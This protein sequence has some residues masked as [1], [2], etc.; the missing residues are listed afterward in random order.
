MTERN[1]RRRRKLS[2]ADVEPDIPGLA[3]L[4]EADAE[5]V[6]WHMPGYVLTAGL[7]L[8]EGRPG[9]GKTSIA[10][11][12]AAA[13]SGGRG[14]PGWSPRSAG[15]VIWD[16]GEDGYRSIV[17]PR[18]MAAGANLRYI[19]RPDLRDSHGRPRRL[20][21]PDDIHDLETMIT[22]WPAR[23]LVLDPYSSCIA[24]G[25]D[26]TKDQQTR[27]VL[28]PLGQMLERT[29]CVGLITRF[30]RKGTLGDVTEHGMGGITVTGL[31]RLVMRADDHP[32]EAG[33]YTLS[34]VRCKDGPR[35]ATHLFRP[36]DAGTGYPHL[37][38][39]GE[40]ALTASEIA[41]GGADS[42][43]RDEWSEADRLLYG[44]IGATHCEAGTIQREAQIAGISWSTIR[45]AK[46]RLGVKTKREA[47][48]K[49]GH[50]EWH[51][52]DKGWPA[53]LIKGE[54][55]AHSE[56]MSALPPKKRAS[57]KQPPQP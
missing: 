24:S 34:V 35:A 51:K 6:T 27:S 44:L 13:L 54:Q 56:R 48:G 45:R 15:R 20:I 31:C 23:M 37:E 30:L 41:E 21:L 52:P 57:K 55:G 53:S 17:I 42:T 1:G 19:R 32:Y 47:K 46:T 50:W 22:A 5:P 29:G 43:L 28:E 14:M 3:D 8:I 38:W 10:T 16:A 9:K 2:P 25:I 18:L 4:S 11:A 26:L 40:S 36:V 49:D 12:M 7:H 33:I 39:D